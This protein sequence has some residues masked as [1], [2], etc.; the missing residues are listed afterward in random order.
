MLP[1]IGA[2]TWIWVSPLTDERLAELAPKVRGLGFD[3]IELPVENRGDWDPGRAADVLAEHGLGATLC[4]AMRAHDVHREITITEAEPS[5]T[6]E[7]VERDH[8]VPGL[9]DAAPAE[10]RIVLA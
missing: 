4:A 10:L 7:A 2:N 3:V 5:L 9:P 1:R 8:K 6:A